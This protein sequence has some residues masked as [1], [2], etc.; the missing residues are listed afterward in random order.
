MIPEHYKTVWMQTASGKKFFPFDP[1]PDDIDLADIARSLSNIVRFTGHAGQYTVGQHCLI[2]SAIVSPQARPWALMHDATE[3]YFGD[4]ISPLKGL[5]P[6]YK[7]GEERL[8]QIIRAKYGIPYDAAI[9]E[10]VHRGDCWLAV[11]EAERRMHP[12]LVAEWRLK[13]WVDQHPFEPSFEHLHYG[14]AISKSLTNAAVEQHL[15]R[16]FTALVRRG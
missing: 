16:A 9:A 8:A 10:E 15:I 7:E 13:A 6:E 2:L 12:E 5:W 14:S 4:L 11:Q 3:A 1:R